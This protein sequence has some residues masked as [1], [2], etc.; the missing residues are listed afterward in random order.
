MYLVTCFLLLSATQSA[1]AQTTFTFTL[2]RAGHT[3]AGVYNSSGKLV[4]T[5][6]ADAVWTSTGP[7]SCVWD[8]LDDWGAAVPADAYTVKVIAHNTNYV[9]EGVVGNTSDLT[10]GT[11]T[12]SCM[13]FTSTLSFSGTTGCYSVGYSENSPCFF[14]F[15]TAVPQR[16]IASFTGC[17]GGGND[18]GWYYSDADSSQVF[19]ACPATQLTGTTLLTQPGAVCK[20][21]PTTGAVV[22]FTSGTTIYEK[23]HPFTNGVL[24]GT[25][26]SIT[27]L[28]VQK[29]GGT[30]LA[31]S[32]AADN[33]VY[34]L[35]KTSGS[36][37]RSF[38]VAAPKALAIDNNDN[39]W[40]IS[41]SSVYQ[42]SNLSSTPT[43]TGTA[44]TGLVAPI[45]LAVSPSTASQ[46]NLLLVTDGGTSQQIKAFNMSG[47]AQWTFGQA[48]GYTTEPA[49]A[50]DKFWFFNP[51]ANMEQ[52]SVAFQPDGTF[53]VVDAMNSRV[54]HYQ[55]GDTAGALPIY[56]NQIAFLGAFYV[57][58]IDKN[59]PTRVFAVSTGKWLEYKIDYSKTLGGTTG[60]WTL[61]KNWGHSS[62]LTTGTFTGFTLQGFKAV[63][64][65]SNGR[66]YGLITN[67]KTFK[68]AVV[69]L[70]ATGQLRF[71]G[72]PETSAP[73]LNADGSLRFQ[74]KV[75]NVSTFSQ[76]SLTGFDA[77]GNPL[78]SGTT[79]LAT[80]PAVTGTDPT[81]GSS[82]GGPRFPITSSNKLIFFD[83]SKNAGMHLGGIDLNGSTTQ[84]AWESSPSVN[85][86]PNGDPQ[87]PLWGDGS[88]DIVSTIQYAGALSDAIGRNVIYE[89]KGEFWNN[90][91]ANQIMHYYDNGLFVGQ[92]GTS[93]GQGVT[94]NLPGAAGNIMM[95]NLA[96]ANGNTYLYLNDESQHGGIHR[97]RLDGL[98]TI[99]ELAGSGTLN[100]SISLT[101]TA[102]IGSAP[103][104]SGVPG[105]VAGLMAT[106]GNGSNYLQWTGTNAVSYQIRRSTT[107]NNGFEIIATSLFL[108]AFTDP[109][110]NNDTTYYY[111]VIP[112]NEKGAGYASKQ[113]V[114]TPSTNRSVYEAEKGTLVG[115]TV[116]LDR[117]ASGNYYASDT[118]TGSV[119][120][121]NV[122]G[123]LTS[124]TVAMAIRYT[125][126]YGTYS[127]ANLTVNGT[128]VT[129]PS[130]PQTAAGVYNDLLI[131]IPLNSGTNNTLVLNKGPMVDKFTV[132]ID[133]PFAPVVIPP[134]GSVKVEIEN[135]D[136]GGEGVAF[137][138]S[139]STFNAG[140]RYPDSPEI[141]NYPSASNGYYV[142]YC[143]AGEWFKYT[144]TVPT[145]GAYIFTVYASTPSSTATL[146]LEDELGNNLT[147][148]MT[149]TNTGGWYTFVGN[150]CTVNLTAGTHILKL[151]ENTG[152]YDLDYFTLSH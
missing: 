152:N 53:W 41:G 93:G 125:W 145:T 126:K 135:Y 87:I 40:V 26:P 52:A 6:W 18:Y 88:Y 32:V 127:G 72:L 134:T 2:A 105:A 47:V 147:G 71:T 7:F 114:V 83:N 106:G 56:Q 144:V 146:H 8:N 36:V 102:P 55:L 22:A 76:Q 103:G 19:F 74:T 37:V 123:G 141:S 139:T 11:T 79:T 67:N 4:R 49:V 63:S 116:R 95:G 58:A 45:A 118:G 21:N 92:F 66:T 150:S 61:M 86:G 35:D 5:L 109:N 62:A 54:M 143:G 115:S 24:V 80:A 124:G 81:S 130:F 128:A 140:Y 14:S 98:S 136:I 78:W 17:S 27:G 29:N 138:N 1:D 107:S 112:V 30:L 42:Y 20:F 65:L 122:N 133:T 82:S 99:G 69:E 84:W 50:T 132:F 85:A 151:V 3:S 148:T 59:N 142:G 100:S 12:H 73:Y 77:S 89:Y 96:S 94:P 117:N 129:L 97:W 10:S 90:T 91:E 111:Q 28:A 64:T 120:I 101:G 16:T 110:V 33:L 119:T 38:S 70:P 137:H 23:Y 39:L 46:P 44:S 48:N 31:V 34:L 43:L 121:N 15:L 104:T 131:N 149:M 113:V 51:E 75:S 108:T 57:T 9:W 68:Q 25:Q 13:H 60:A